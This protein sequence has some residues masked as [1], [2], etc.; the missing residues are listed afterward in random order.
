FFSYDKPKGAPVDWKLTETIR[1]NISEAIRENISEA[2][3]KDN[4]RSFARNFLPRKG[5]H[6]GYSKET[7][8][9]LEE[10][11]YIWRL[12]NMGIPKEKLGTIKSVGNIVA[13][14]SKNNISLFYKLDKTRTIDEFWSVLR[15]ISRKLI[16]FEDKTLI[17]PT[18]FDEIIQLVKEHEDKWKE[19]RDL[20]VVYS[21][22]YYSIGERKEGDVNE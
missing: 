11:I 18:A 20:L 9:N 1:E 12:R 6:V 3:L 19:I 17:R 7:R 13:K 21:S 15:E 2:I 10:L 5:G 8:Q 22:M 16:G 14:V 4:F